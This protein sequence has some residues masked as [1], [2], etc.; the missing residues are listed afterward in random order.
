MFLVHGPFKMGQIPELQGPADVFYNEKESIN[1]TKCSRIQY[2]QKKI[3]Q[4]CIELLEMEEKGLI[5]DIGCGSGLSGSVISEYGHN[6]IGIDLSKDMLNIAKTEGE[7]LEY[8]RM[9]MGEGLPFQ[10]GT[11]DG[12]IS[13]SAL[14]WIFH[15]Y[16]ANQLPIKRIRK[17]F[18]T[19]Y[20]AC[21][22]NAK[23]VL[24]Y[25]L[26]NTKDV[27][28]LKN[29]ALRAGFGG[30]IHIEDQ[31]TKN[32]KS[33]LVLTNGIVK[34]KKNIKKRKVNTRLEKLLIKKDR[35]RRKGVKVS[36]DSR[37]TGKRRS[38]W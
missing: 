30:G 16:S 23:C 38:K 3:S 10:P 8:I 9:D 14:Q 4:R 17:F 12:I 35:L 24:Q 22:P 26:K 21:K 34:S 7:A 13:V 19:L 37:Y 18:T 31:G 2:I 1:Y 28:T 11:F 36:D 20:S 15:S 33:F 27:E 32:V 6:W 25:Y 5:L 29:E